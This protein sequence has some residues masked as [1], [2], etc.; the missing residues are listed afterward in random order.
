MGELKQFFI[1]NWQLIASAVLFLIAVVVGI[2]QRCKKGYS[3][4]DVIL[5][6]ITEELP[7]WI[8]IAEGTGTGE[9]KKVKVLNYALSFASKKLGRQLTEQEVALITTYTTEQI[10]KIL[11]T[12]QK[13]ESEQVS[14][15]GKKNA[16]YR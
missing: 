1:N 2:I 3:V 16:H 8:S 7:N 6:L 15:G 5:G 14:K 12:P 9:Q 10:E 13:K 4:S 11:N